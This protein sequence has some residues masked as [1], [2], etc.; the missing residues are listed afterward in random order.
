MKRWQEHKR[1]YIGYHQDNDKTELLLY[2]KQISIILKHKC[3]HIHISINL[4]Q[5]EL[6]R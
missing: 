2:C 1:G 5:Y 6:M 4:V 3:Q